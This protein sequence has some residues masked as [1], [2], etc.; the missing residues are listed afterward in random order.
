MARETKKKSR[1]RKSA[2]G[3]QLVADASNYDPEAYA[4]PA[5]TVDVAICMIRDGA[6]KVLLI[7]RRHPPFAGLWALPGGFVR[8]ESGEN[9]D[10]SARRELREE[11]GV[12]DVYLEQLKTYGAPDRDPR[13]RVITVAYYALLAPD[14][15]L[16]IAAGEEAR[17]VRWFALN[18]LPELA[19]D[20]ATILTDLLVR[21]QGK[22]EYAPLAFTLVPGQFTWP[23]L[24]D[25]YEIILG[26]SLLTPNF[27]RKM[28]SMYK[29]EELKS[30]RASDMAGK[31]PRYLR[32]RGVRGPT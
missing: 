10:E 31:P 27:R 22:I 23:D 28:K 12:S 1:S 2:E 14:A 11:T 19:F 29:I 30:T 7:K 3:Q 6:L 16:S 17:D 8:I 18:E 25:V 24:Q 20:H 21:L 4:R 5:V 9:L 13:T 26:K 15:E 32:Y